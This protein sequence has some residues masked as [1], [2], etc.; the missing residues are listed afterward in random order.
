MIP[1]YQAHAYS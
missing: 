1:A